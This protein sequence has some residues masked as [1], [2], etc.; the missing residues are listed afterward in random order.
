[1][2]S[3]CRATNP[4]TCPYHGN[5]TISNLQAQADQAAMSGNISEYIA[6]REQMD[7]AQDAL[8]S[9][10]T[11]KP[12]ATKPAPVKPAAAKRTIR[13]TSQQMIE[14]GTNAALKHIADSREM[15]A[16]ARPYPAEEEVQMVKRGL[17]E[18]VT[19]GIQAARKKHP[20]KK[21]TTEQEAIDEVAYVL[22]DSF[23]GEN[24]PS[25]G[26]F[27]RSLYFQNLG[28]TILEAAISAK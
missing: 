28:K 22:F 11:E 19:K 9:Q 26:L 18:E 25:V 6:L 10:P 3:E 23:Y 24:K 7:A 4:T 16:D 14:A 21:L 17:R 15:E 27:H 1:M 13:R 12:I 20:N 5:T 8:H 2:K